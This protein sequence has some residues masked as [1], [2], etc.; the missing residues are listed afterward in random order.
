[1]RGSNSSRLNSCALIDTTAKVHLPGP[2]NPGECHLYLA[3]GCHLYMAAKVC[4]SQNFRLWKEPD[5]ARA[6][7]GNSPNAAL[8]RCPR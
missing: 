7:V 6:V 2:Q 1:M 5:S 3:E 4:V 8:A